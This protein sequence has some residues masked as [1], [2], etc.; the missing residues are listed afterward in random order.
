MFYV[1]RD[2][3]LGADDIEKPTSQLETQDIFVDLIRY[4]DSFYYHLSSHTNQ[5]FI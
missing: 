3:S 1:G 2:G 5:L 4:E